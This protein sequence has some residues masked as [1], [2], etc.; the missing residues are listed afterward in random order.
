MTWNNIHHQSNVD[1][2]DYHMRSAKYPRGLILDGSDFLSHDID[3]QYMSDLESHP[4]QFIFY[5]LIKNNTATRF[6]NEFQFKTH[7]VTILVLIIKL[8][9]RKIH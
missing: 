6:W 3:V 2:T 1:T 7:V 9:C 5:A 8:Y 4:S